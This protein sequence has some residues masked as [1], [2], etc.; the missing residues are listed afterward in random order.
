MYEGYTRRVECQNVDA[1]GREIH[2][3][4]IDDILENLKDRFQRRSL[5]G[6]EVHS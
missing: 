5:N 4:V 1:T 2:I 6:L 3:D